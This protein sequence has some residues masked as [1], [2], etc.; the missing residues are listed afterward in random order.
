MMKQSLSVTEPT[1]Y[2]IR[3]SGRV[4]NGWSDFMTSYEQTVAYENGLTVTVI[5]GIVSDQAALFG[6]LCRI[7]DLGLALVSVE[8][9][10]NLNQEK[11]EDHE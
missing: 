3:V 4:G 1:A 5:T 10:P 11:G 7:R 2:S 8:Y 6:M 9:L